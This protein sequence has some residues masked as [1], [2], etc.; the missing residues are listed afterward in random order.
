MIRFNRTTEYGLIALRHMSRKAR[1]GASAEVASAREIADYYALPFEITAKTLQRLKDGGLIRSAQGARG[2][3]T[4]G[5]AMTEV[6]LVDFLEIMEG[7]Q[8]VVPCCLDFWDEDEAKEVAADA[9]Q[10]LAAPSCDYIG[11][12]EIKDVMAQFNS[13]VLQ[14][15]GAIRLSEITDASGRSSASSHMHSMGEEP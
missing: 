4:L 1:S 14:F 7:P 2:G 5:K 3:Y 15:H 9:K 6:T 13:K 12:C 11:R 8:G 10:P